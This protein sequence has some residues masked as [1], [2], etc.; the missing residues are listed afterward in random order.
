MSSAVTVIF[1]RED[2]SIP[3][4][5]ESPKSLEARFFD[6]ISRSNPDVIVLDLSRAP[7]EGVGTI[8]MVRQ[9]TDVPILVVC[10]SADA[11]VDE[12]RIAGAADCLPVPVDIIGLNQRIQKILQ[13]R[14][15]GRSVSG[16]VPMNFR[17]AG[18]GFD[19]GHN[20]IASEDG[21]TVGLTS[22]EGRL[23]AHFMSKPW[24]L[25]TRNE[26]TE[27]LYGG[28]ER[29]GDRAIDVVVNRLRKKLSSAGGA[30]TGRL[31]KTEFRRGYLLVAEVSRVPHEPHDKP[32]AHSHRLDAA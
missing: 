18:I 29:V 27:L 32:P 13:V 2:L 8:L 12:Y 15:R 5:A 17:F 7:A 19:P 9:Q 10:E 21:S 23:L 20:L 30:E 11:S 26:L 3:G 24:T 22:S 16:R 28:E 6:L 4:D 14:S 1:A 31:I 25:C